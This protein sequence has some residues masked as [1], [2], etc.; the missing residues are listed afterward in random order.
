MTSLTILFKV[1]SSGLL[2]HHI[3]LANLQTLLMALVQPSLIDAHFRHARKPFFVVKV[4]LQL[5]PQAFSKYV[6]E[7]LPLYAFLHM[8]FLQVKTCTKQLC[9]RAPQQG[10]CVAGLGKKLQSFLCLGLLDQG[11]FVC[12]VEALGHCPQN[13]FDAHIAFFPNPKELARPLDRAPL[14]SF[15][16]STTPGLRF[17]CLAFI[18]VLFLG[19]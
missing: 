15:Q 13:L 5:P 14:A 10:D 18:L 17:G 12:Q 7:H 16:L 1:A 19:A 9:R 8:P 6:G 4:I 2:L 3:W 11:Q